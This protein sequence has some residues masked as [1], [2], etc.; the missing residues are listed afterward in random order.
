MKK[1]DVSP[2]ALIPE[3][4]LVA[5]ILWFGVAM[6]QPVLNGI[7]Q[8]TAIVLQQDDTAALHEAPL[9]RDLFATTDG[10]HT[11]DQAMPPASSSK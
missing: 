3:V 1:G 5:L 8:A 10:A 4:V 9:F 6:P 7:E 2:V 11:H